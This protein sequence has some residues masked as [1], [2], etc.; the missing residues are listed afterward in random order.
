MQL[1]TDQAE[2]I[3]QFADS[4]DVQVYERY[5]GRG[6]YGKQCFGLV[7][8]SLTSTAMKLACFLMEDGNDELALSLS[9]RIGED[10]MGTDSIIYFPGHE[11]PVEEELEDDREDE[12]VVL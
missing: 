8:R 3:Q 5:S 2:L 11:W 9:N 1:T 6:M 12:L 10:S 4:E 7:G